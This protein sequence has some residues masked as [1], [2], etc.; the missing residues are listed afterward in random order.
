MI[1]CDHSP[2]PNELE[3]YVLRNI[4]TDDDEKTVSM[5]MKT[6]IANDPASYAIRLMQPVSDS[7]PQVKLGDTFSTFK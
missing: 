1:S 7:R 6:L 4:G 2:K 5:T 3:P